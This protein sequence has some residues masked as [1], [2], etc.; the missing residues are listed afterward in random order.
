[1]ENN[2]WNTTLEH[3]EATSSS[4]TFTTWF[5][6]SKLLSNK[7][8]NLIIEVP[9]EFIKNHLQ[10][11]YEETID[12][13]LK[14]VS[15][16]LYTFEI[17]VEGEHKEEIII[18]E[19]KEE[20]VDLPKFKNLNNNLMSKYT[21]DNFMVG[22]SN[23]FAQ[24]VA[25]SVAEQP[26]KLYNPL[27]LYGK[28]G[29]GKTH[30]MNAIGNYIVSN[31]NKSVLYV[32]PDEFINDFR[33]I[34]Q[35]G[36]NNYE[37]TEHFKEKYRN[38]DVLIIDDIQMICGANKTQI[39]LFNTFNFLH[40]LN[41]QMIISSDRSPDDLKELEDRLR[42]RFTMGLTVDILPPDR[43][44]KLKIVKNCTAEHEVAK[45]IPNEVF[46]YI[47]NNC[48]SD[49]RHLT[50][51]VNRLYA[52]ISIWNPPEIT[53]EFAVN[54]LRDLVGNSIYTTNDVKKIQKAVAD[55]YD[56]T[57]ENLKSKKRTANINLA[58]QIA[59]YLC[60][61]TTEETL[62]RIGLEFNKNHSTVI[63][64]CEKIEEELKTNEQLRKDINEI[65]NKISN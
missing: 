11:Y 48:D 41:K 64:S 29:T 46:E 55:Y 25:L 24:T 23:R 6:D 61:L 2:I 5:K 3:L 52:A 62:E 8:N 51:A 22:E 13:A 49:G 7:N 43:E 47:A 57:V 9:N 31:S 58:R 4:I 63:H 39:E 17:V 42:Q 45:L 27:F 10:Q 59:M 53:L 40:G 14:A 18:P 21:F 34:S 50:G 65:K 30:L 26:G 16:T 38:I 12:E 1:M 15:N 37:L 35:K 56:L 60:K 19:E 54:N 20:V 28:S 33:E 32:R 36:S 44:L